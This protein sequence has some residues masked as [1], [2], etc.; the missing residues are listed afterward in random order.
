MVYDTVNKPS[1]ADV[2]ALA[3]GAKAADSDLLDG[4]NSS[5][6]ITANTIALRDGSADLHCRLLRSNYGMQTSVPVATAGLAFRVSTTDNYIRTMD[7]A[8]AQGWLDLATSYL[9]ISDKAADSN[10]LDGLDSSV[11]LRSNTSDVFSG[12]LLTI[13]ADS[14]A[15]I[16]NTGSQVGGLEIKQNTAGKDAMM[17]FHI[18]GDYACHFGLD[19]TTNKMSVGGYSMGANNYALYHEGNKP[20]AADVG[21]LAS[22][23]NAV[24]A[25]KL[26][27]ARTISLGGDCSG[28]VTFDGSANATIT[29]V[30]NN[31]SH[32][33]ATQY[34]GLTAKAADT[35]LCDGLVVSPPA[36]VN[37]VAN[38]VVT[39]NANGYLNV[40]WLNTVSGSATGT[41]TRIYCSQDAYL[42]YYTPAQLAPYILNQ[43][44]TKNSHTH[45]AADVGALAVGANAVSASKLATA[46]TISLGGDCSG[47]ASF[48]GSANV[49]ITAVV[50]NDSH[51]HA[52]QYLGLTAKAADSQK[53]DGIDSTGFVKSNKV[54]AFSED[55]ANS[56][57]TISTWEHTF[58]LP[59]GVAYDGTWMVHAWIAYGAGSY[60]VYSSTVLESDWPIN[61]SQSYSRSCVFGGSTSGSSSYFVRTN[62]NEMRV[63]YTDTAFDYMRV[64]FTKIL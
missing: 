13:E 45:T 40:G 33:H 24:S 29:A 15:L 10:L 28:S 58:T 44:S 60:H 21:A 16:E 23:A 6:G 11:F 59:A 30:V 35:T 12:G 31:D 62:T 43:G 51:T 39:T 34:L 3:V 42:R 32:T 61:A 46:R 48:D 53:L 9:G 56:A 47:S 38:Q 54:V 22:G 7:K 49:T 18:A 19:A 52:T 37:N 20:T 55:L 50:N 36:N 5:S 26:A 14:T 2:G 4:Y 17:Q 27:T 57:S 25:T 64:Y 63:D 1:A 41:P 8:S